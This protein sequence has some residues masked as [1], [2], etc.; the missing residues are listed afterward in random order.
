MLLLEQLAHHVVDTWEK[1]D[2]AA[3]V[4]SLDGQLKEIRV[5]R[6]AHEETIETARKRYVETSD[7]NM[8][9]KALAGALKNKA[10]VG[11]WFTRK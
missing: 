7:N 3:A 1:G 5:N 6:E 11:I 8:A 2:L 9:A 4:R 10:K